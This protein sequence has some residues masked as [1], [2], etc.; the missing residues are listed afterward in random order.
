[1]GL[2]QVQTI[3][4]RLLLVWPLNH[5]DKD[6]DRWIQSSGTLMRKDQEYGPWLWA[7]PLPMHNNAVIVVLRYYETKKKELDT[8]NRQGK[9][10]TFKPREAHG[11]A[12]MT[13]QGG[14]HGG[15]PMDYQFQKFNT[16][17]IEEEV[18]EVTKLSAGGNVESIQQ[19]G[20]AVNRG[21]Y[22]NDKINEIDSEL[23]KFVLKKDSN[24]R[25]AMNV[26]TDSTE[27]CITK[28]C[29]E[30]SI[31]SQIGFEARA[32]LNEHNHHVANIEENPKEHGIHVPAK[33]AE[34]R[35]N[36]QGV[37]AYPSFAWKRIIQA[38]NNEARVVPHLITLKHTSTEIFDSELPKKKKQVSHDNQDTLIQLATVDIPPPP[39]RSNEYLMLELSWAW[40]PTDKSRALRFDLSTRSHSH[41]L[42]QNMA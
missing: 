23:G 10:T 25:I 30:I 2:F 18:M 42:S 21:D 8:G 4:K 5:F 6:C 36:T 41:V 35:A 3:T 7:F 27:D 38:K 24:C 9:K 17:I 19:R 32:D 40:E 34:S 15:G 26:E 33:Q 1:M 20:G 12:D 13:E 16:P 37:A 14:T 28:D 31:Q 29:G 11:N 39:P 22:F